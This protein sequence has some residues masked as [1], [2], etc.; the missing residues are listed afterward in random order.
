ME[1][2]Q[3]YINS[4]DYSKLHAKE[5]FKH[6]ICVKLRP[7]YP[8]LKIDLIIDDMLIDIKSHNKIR[9]WTKDFIQ[10]LTYY[11]LLINRPFTITLHHNKVFQG[12]IKQ[13]LSYKKL[14]PLN[15]KRLGIYFSRFDY[16]WTFNIMDIID[17]DSIIDP[18]TLPL[19][20]RYKYVS[21]FELLDI[22]YTSIGKYNLDY[23]KVKA[24]IKHF[25]KTGDTKLLEILALF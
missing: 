6:D 24:L 8:D 14:K 21:P 3:E 16:L 19:W 25:I 9:F 18:E 15:I 22:F 4:I 20:E 17:P 13:D 12:N 1:V 11:Y 23:R 7:R 2:I 10:L 5:I